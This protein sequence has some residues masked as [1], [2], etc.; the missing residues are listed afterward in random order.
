[1]SIAFTKGD[2]G[3][4]VVALQQKILALNS[5]ALP[6]FGADG[7]LGDETLSALG[8]LLN[9]E[10]ISSGDVVTTAHLQSL[11]A[12]VLASRPSVG[13]KG[14][15]VDRRG[16]ADKT[17]RHGKRT[18]TEYDLV[19]HQ[20]DCEMGERPARY[21]GVPVH[22]VVTSGGQIIQLHDVTELLWAAHALNATGISIEV[23]GHFEGIEGDTGDASY[24]DY[25]KD[26]GRTPQ[27]IPLVQVEAAKECARIIQLQ[28]T[29][30]GATIKRQCTHRQGVKGKRRRD[31]G[32]KVCRLIVRPLEAEIA[33][34]DW[35]Y[36][37]GDGEKAPKEWHPQSTAKY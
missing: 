9:D 12:L 16:E 17:K 37:K 23:E 4:K 11:D 30:F 34:F 35:A 1:M 32:G 8:D 14:V 33:P 5:L 26:A 13:G 7:D 3:P 20:T 24:P 31:P 6:R 25:H 10:F 18:R 29:E 22:F 36:T 19:W 28:L 27:D 21:D 15:Y 2:K